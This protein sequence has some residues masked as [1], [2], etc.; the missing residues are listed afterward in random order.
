M[1][2]FEVTPTTASSASARASR[3]DAS[4]SRDRKSIQTLWAWS[5]SRWRGVLNSFISV[6]AVALGDDVPFLHSRFGERVLHALGHRGWT[7]HEERVL[8]QV[9]VQVVREEL[10]VDLPRLALPARVLRHRE[11]EAEVPE[12]PLEVAEFFEEGGRL[13]VAVRVDQRH[14]ITEPLLADVAEHAAEDGDPDSAG[15]EDERSSGVVG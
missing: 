3:P 10:G 9:P 2:G 4:R 14:A 15:D 7:G 8:V 11:D 6:A 13:A 5:A 12:F 1:V